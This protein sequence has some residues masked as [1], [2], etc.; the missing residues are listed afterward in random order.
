[1]KTH[2][3]ERKEILP[4]DIET[5]WEFFSNPDNLPAITPPELDLR[6]TSGAE[7]RIYPGMI[8]TYEIKLA[9]FVG[10]GW[11]T[12]ITHVDAPRYFVDEQRAGPYRL[13][14]HKHFFAETGR[15]GTEARD[16]VHYSLP[17]GPLGAAAHRLF[18]RRRLDSIFDY[19]SS[20]LAELLG[21]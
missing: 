20:R 19:R 12:E 16:V 6:V 11:V 13:W 15:G 10:S 9:P 21:T 4:V 3:L 5:A 1:M 18:V 14:H 2:I 17:F 7:E 8:I